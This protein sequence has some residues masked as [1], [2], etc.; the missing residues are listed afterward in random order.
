MKKKL[1]GSC[2]FKKMDR[3]VTVGDVFEMHCTWPVEAA[4]SPLLH[5][6]LAT[7]STDDLHF[8][9]LSNVYQLAILKTVQMKKGYGVFQVTSYQPGNHHISLRLVSAADSIYFTTTEL[10]VTSVIPKD[11][12][13][14][15]QPYPP[16]GPWITPLPVW[17]WPLG[18]A[19][20]AALIIFITV[21]LRSFFKRKKWIANIHLRRQ[22]YNSFSRFTYELILLERTL[23]TIQP[24]DFI[25]KLKKTFSDF[26]EEE[27]L[28]LVHNHSLKTTVRMLKQYH[29]DIYKIHHYHLSQFFMELEN[30]ESETVLNKKDYE[31]LLNMGRELGIQL[32]LLARKQRGDK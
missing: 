29:P 24:A 27:F 4:L 15:I 10:K 18:I 6:E 9:P 3:L 21:R 23:D 28:V 26:L 13:Q 20:I 12:A 7:S 22:K 1:T 31:Q 17:Y 11:K 16:Y 8:V 19:L 14:T 2:S 32:F 30:I 25:Q 5:W